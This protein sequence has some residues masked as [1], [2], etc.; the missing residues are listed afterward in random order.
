MGLENHK[1]WALF[2]AFLIATLL[3]L[4]AWYMTQEGRFG[5]GFLDW[6]SG[7]G[8]RFGGRGG[9]LAPAPYQGTTPPDGGI[10]PVPVPTPDRPEKK[11]EATPKKEEKKE[12]G[13]PWG[14]IAGYGGGGLLAVVLLLLLLFWKHKGKIPPLTP[15]AISI[16]GK[17]KAID[18][19]TN[20]QDGKKK[21]LE[22][23]WDIREKPPKQGLMGADSD[24]WRAY[25]RPPTYLVGHAVKKFIL[26]KHLYETVWQ[27]WFLQ[28]DNKERIKQLNQ[29]IN[30]IE[31]MENG[32]LKMFT[33]NKDRLNDVLKKV[34]HDNYIVG[35]ILR[36]IKVLEGGIS[37]CN[38][39]IGFAGKIKIPLKQEEGVT[40]TE[41]IHLN[42]QKALGESQAAFEKRLEDRLSGK[43]AKT[44]VEAIKQIIESCLKT[45][46]TPF[47][48]THLTT[49]CQF[50]FINLMITKLNE[51]IKILKSLSE[52]KKPTIFSVNP[53][54]GPASGG[55]TVTIYCANIGQ[56]TRILLG[57]NPL[58]NVQIDLK[59]TSIKGVTPA[60]PP[61]QTVDLVIE[62]N[63]FK[64]TLEKA[65]TYDSRISGKVI[66]ANTD[67]GVGNAEV[68]AAEA[69]PGLI[70][71][72]GNKTLI[73]KQELEKALENR[74]RFNANK[75]TEN[76]GGFIID[77]VKAGTKNIIVI[78]YHED[79]LGI[80]YHTNTALG[81]S[82][83]N[84]IPTIT[85]LIDNIKVPLVLRG[86]YVT[87]KGK[88]IEG[89]PTTQRG[90]VNYIPRG[91]G[92]VP[93]DSY[94][95][96]APTI[97]N[98]RGDHK[99]DDGQRSNPRIGEIVREEFR[100]RKIRGEDV[101]IQQVW[102]EVVAREQGPSDVPDLNKRYA[103]MGNG[104]LRIPQ[105]ASSLKWKQSGQPNNK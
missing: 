95:Y 34:G 55:T 32:Y 46:T 63:T 8:G 68:I 98:A 85:G 30:H 93:I 104:Q 33:D 10:Q 51:Q 84:P 11:E 103:E 92:M 42:E 67:E 96:L 86:N 24:N 18:E 52:I 72:L 14:K 54:R 76:D 41:L 21:L 77:G 3:V 6:F 70:Q 38:E 61:G 62:A 58:T 22:K 13:L 82:G 101:T 69:F 17:K 20:I 1:G 50:H 5:T 80:G 73:T 43:W 102:S 64:A 40:D 12:D 57:S 26:R 7:L 105:E 25:L 89:K 66:K 49:D 45:T 44:R 91:G 28:L 59:G 15:L 16:E 29:G 71:R 27:L 81:G 99:Q 9:P 48:V 36:E 94:G 35:Q 75:K 83:L 65:F 78:A 19:L 37:I 87:F 53:N 100:R 88:V 74:P 97:I 31:R 60:G 79:A 90:M 4:W 56:A 23:M 39:V 47:D 2:L